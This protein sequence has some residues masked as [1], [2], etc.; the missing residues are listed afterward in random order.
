VSG[1]HYHQSDL[2]CPKCGD[3]LEY[4]EDESLRTVEIVCDCGTKLEV[5]EML[6]YDVVIVE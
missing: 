6:T 5:T 3:E 2:W 4:P 1:Q